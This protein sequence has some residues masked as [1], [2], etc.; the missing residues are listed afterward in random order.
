[1]RRWGEELDNFADSAALIGNL[2]LVITVDTAIAHLAGA[3]GKPVW[4]LLPK[5]A[6]W[7][8]LIDR[9]DSPWYTSA[10]LFRQTVAGDWATVI[11][12]VIEKLN[13]MNGTERDSFVAKGSAVAHRLRARAREQ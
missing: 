2:D 3:L 1:V 10:R 9:P 4:I 5:V 11:A 8:W 6:D 12:R 13:A 7:R